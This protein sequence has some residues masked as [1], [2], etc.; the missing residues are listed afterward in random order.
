ME[1]MLKKPADSELSSSMDDDSAG[2]EEGGKQK[3]VDDVE[4]GVVVPDNSA[5]MRTQ[6]SDVKDDAEYTHVLIPRPGHAIANIHVQGLEDCCMN[7]EMNTKRISFSRKI[8][9]R[10]SKVGQDIQDAI[11]G[12]GQ[13]EVGVSCTTGDLNDPVDKV[14]TERRAVPMF[15]AVCLTKYEINDR[16]CWS[17]NSECSHIFHEDCMRQWLVA[18]GTKHSRRKR[19]SKNPSEKKLLDFD[20]TCP[21]CRQDFISRNA[22][23]G[24]EENV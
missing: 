3:H 1:N 9:F 20:L 12:T 7:N 17:S 4:M 13:G 22:I 24:N 18:L 10:A 5:Q 15:C 16:V 14:V 2:R 19:Y 23:L 8:L 6:Y 21:C 11:N